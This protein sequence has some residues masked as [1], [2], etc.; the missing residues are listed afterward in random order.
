M[1]T[2][3]TAALLA[4][5]TLIATGCRNLPPDEIQRVTVSFYNPFPPEAVQPP[6]VFDFS[7]DELRQFR[8]LCPDLAKTKG[9]GCESVSPP[10]TFSVHYRDGQSVKAQFCGDSIR[11]IDPGG[12]LDPP[13]GLR[14]FLLKTIQART[15]ELNWG[16]AIK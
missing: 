8:R 10:F 4:I 2:L 9:P 11:T 13:P 5:T 14:D 3:L 12:N 6:T 15:G 7:A 1:R 16:N